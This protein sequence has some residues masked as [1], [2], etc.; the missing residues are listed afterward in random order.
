M[1]A[2]RDLPVVPPRPLRVVLAESSSFMRRR[3]VAALE[4]AGDVRVVAAVG[5]G[6]E[7][8]A[9]TAEL[10]PDVVVLE[11]NL[12][13]VDGLVVIARIMRHRPLPIVATGDQARPEAPAGR[14]ALEA[15]A[16]DLAPRPPGVLLDSEEFSADLLF[17]VR[18]AARVRVVRSGQAARSTAST[19]PWAPP[20]VW[21]A[22]GDPFPVVV[23]AASTGGPALVMELAARWA[24]SPL[25]AMLVAQH[26]P[27]NFTAEFARLWQEVCPAAEIRE[28]QP[29]DFPRPGLVLVA[30]GGQNL[31]LTAAGAVRLAPGRS[32]TPW[33]PSADRLFTTAAEAFGTRVRAFVLTGMGDDGAAGVRAVARAGGLAWAQDAASCVVD[34]M[35]A[36]ARATGHA[37]ART[38]DEI[39]ALIAGLASTTTLP[40]VVP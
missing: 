14:A 23:L 33:L 38:P 13:R 11:I 7:A 26:L 16:V 10:E 4:A 28:A 8:L 39:A 15:G 6:E 35:P 34:G 18:R 29:G 30:P 5:D 17:R 20:V 22:P 12:P 32:E 27:A 2:P 21:N 19:A 40:E 25:P 1:S 31:E 37:L 3:L 9:R 36:A 24:D